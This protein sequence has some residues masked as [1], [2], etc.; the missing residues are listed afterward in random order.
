[1]DISIFKEIEIIPNTEKKR[2]LITICLP[3][4][5]GVCAI[6]KI[7]ETVKLKVRYIPTSY[8]IETSSFRKVFSNFHGEFTFEEFV[9]KLYDYLEKELKCEKLEVELF[10]D[11]GKLIDWGVKYG[12]L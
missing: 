12:T 7:T 5:V 4:I 2:F 10:R 9:S 8:L 1:M 6:A 11:D 3:G